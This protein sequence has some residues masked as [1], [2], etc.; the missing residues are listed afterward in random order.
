MWPRH[1]HS[2]GRNVHRQSVDQAFNII[3][4]AG[5]LH[6]MDKGGGIA[7]FRRGRGHKLAMPKD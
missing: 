6:V 3:K 1:C 5:K 7:S 4:S 2:C